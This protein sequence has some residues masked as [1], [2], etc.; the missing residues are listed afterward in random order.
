MMDEDEEGDG[1]GREATGPWQGGGGAL[2][3]ESIS[4]QPACLALS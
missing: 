4:R 1:R 2:G 3:E